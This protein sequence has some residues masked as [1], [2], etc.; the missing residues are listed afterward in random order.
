MLYVLSLA[1]L[2][3]S[4][5]YVKYMYILDLNLFLFIHLFLHF[6]VQTFK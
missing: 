1:I 5:F 4:G 3:V 2:I 6:K